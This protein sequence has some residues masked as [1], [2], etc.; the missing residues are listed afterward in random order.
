LYT[1]GWKLKPKDL[2]KK[3]RECSGVNPV[4]WHSYKI[5]ATFSDEDTELL[6]KYWTK[7][8]IKK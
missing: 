2:A 1:F 6:T 3:Q 8:P 7:Y 5:R 4:S